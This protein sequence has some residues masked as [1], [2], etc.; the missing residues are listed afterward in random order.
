M[1][2][3]GCPVDYFC[4]IICETALEAAPAIQRRPWDK[5][6][7]DRHGLQGRRRKGLGA[8]HVQYR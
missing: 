7:T 8:S 6:L 4:M 5:V 1:C 2:R 3:H